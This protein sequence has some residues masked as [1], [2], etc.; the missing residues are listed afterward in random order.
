MTNE[1][2]AIALLAMPDDFKPKAEAGFFALYFEYQRG[3]ARLSD[4]QAGKVIK[5]L[6]SYAKDYAQS[7]DASLQPDYDGLDAGGEML[8]EMVAGS[9]RRV[10]D[11]RRESAFLKSGLR[12]DGKTGGRPPKT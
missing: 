4:E 7:Y 10:Y 9:I 6:F 2:K 1:E 12:K 8:M 3:F 11:A 5:K